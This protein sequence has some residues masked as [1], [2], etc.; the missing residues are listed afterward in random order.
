[1]LGLGLVIGVIALLLAG[2]LYGLASY[3]STMRSI[4]SKLAELKEAETLK[5]AVQS[6]KERA[7]NGGGAADELKSLVPKARKALQGYEEKLTDTVS[8]RRDPEKGRT[9]MQLVQLIH[10]D[11]D[12]LERR[13]NKAKTFLAAD[14]V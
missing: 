11:L 7:A 12:E 8:H 13:I 2:T 4:D 6:I 3:R 9:E 14:N 10:E 5:G 1:M